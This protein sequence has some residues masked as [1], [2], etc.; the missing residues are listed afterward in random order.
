MSPYT[1]TAGVGREMTAEEVEKRVV[2]YHD[3]QEDTNAFP[4]V[5]DPRF[6]RKIMWAIS[7]DN[8]GGPAP[9]NTDH[10]LHLAILESTPSKG[11]VLHAHPYNEIFLCLE[12]K[13]GIYW[14]DQGEHCVELN[15]LDLFSV[16]PGVMRQVVNIGDG[17][18]KIMA[19]YDFPGDPN[20]DL[21]VPQ[22]VLDRDQAEV[23]SD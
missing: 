6:R 13:Y 1:R 18:G 22:S 14:G 7:P 19:L 20:A 10:N 9:I 12:G 4:D 2:R 21:V 3:L 16:P 23:G 17:P 15:P 8:L 5:Q 11:P